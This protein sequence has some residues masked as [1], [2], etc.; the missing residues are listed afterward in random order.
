MLKIVPQSSGYAFEI[1]AVCCR[2]GGRLQLWLHEIHAGHLL[3]QYGDDW[4]V[5]WLVMQGWR[6]EP[7]E[8]VLCP[9][10]CRAG[11]GFVPTE[12][13]PKP[14]PVHIAAP[15]GLLELLQQSRGGGGDGPAS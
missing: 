7:L 10:C 9:A 4:P 12:Q 8:S 13:T 11:E 1:F 2:C 3:C 6:T 14:E 15:P 5:V